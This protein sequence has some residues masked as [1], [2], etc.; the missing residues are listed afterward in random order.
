[1]PGDGTDLAALNRARSAV[2]DVFAMVAPGRMYVRPIPER[3]RLIFY[4]G[5]VE[6]FDL[7][8]LRTAIDVRSFAPALDRLF[9]FGIDPPAGALPNDSESDWPEPSA[10][11][12]YCAEARSELDASWSEAPELLR[13]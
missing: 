13:H 11:S 9:A 10:V 1:M 5:H 4:I 2:D 3:N 6:A 7:N 12:D 8:L